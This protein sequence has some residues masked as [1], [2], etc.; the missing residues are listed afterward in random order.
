MI[1]N[2]TMFYV[3]LFKKTHY[4]SEQVDGFEY[5]TAFMLYNE[6]AENV[7]YYEFTTRELA[8]EFVALKAVNRDYYHK[9]L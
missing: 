3:F 4:T 6:D 2:E 8:D 7:K 5:G 1:T 9:I